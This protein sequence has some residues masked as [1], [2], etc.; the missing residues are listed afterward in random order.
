[1]KKITN[2]IK[3][4]LIVF[5]ISILWGIYRSILL[6]GYNLKRSFSIKEMEISFQKTSKK[7]KINPKNKKV[8]YV[9]FIPLYVMAS[10]IATIIMVPLNIYLCGKD[11]FKNN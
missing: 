5:L 6:L 1:M 8:Y 7:K 3:N 4:I 10:L 9:W 11:Y 2:L